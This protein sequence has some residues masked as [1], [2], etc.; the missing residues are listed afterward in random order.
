[1]RITER[2]LCSYGF[3]IDKAIPVEAM[4]TAMAEDMEGLEGMEIAV[5]LSTAKSE[6]VLSQF[7]SVPPIEI[8]AAAL[9]AAGE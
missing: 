3:P 6:C 2:I 7:D 5:E 4:R 8:P 1:M 9:A